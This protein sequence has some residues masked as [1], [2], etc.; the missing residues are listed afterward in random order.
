MAKT[1]GRRNGRSQGSFIYKRA[2]RVRTKT[3][4]VAAAA[5]VKARLLGAG[6]AHLLE[7]TWKNLLLAQSLGEPWQDSDEPTQE[8]GLLLLGFGVER[9][10]VEEEEGRDGERREEGVRGRCERGEARGRGA[11]EELREEVWRQD[12]E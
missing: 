7:Q 3:V 10:P 1:L 9:G 8:G 12:A 4:S 6:L 2:D 5:R 11:C